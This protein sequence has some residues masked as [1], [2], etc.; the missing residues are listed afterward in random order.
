MNHKLTIDELPKHG[1]SAP[2]ST[3]TPKEEPVVFDLQSVIDNPPVLPVGFR[4]LI[5]SEIVEQTTESGIIMATDTEQKRRQVG[6]IWGTLIAVGETAFTGPDYTEADRKNAVPGKQV[7]FPRYA[8]TTFDRAGVVEGGAEALYR[9]MPDSDIM[10]IIAADETI[11][12]I[13]E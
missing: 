3:D 6:Q 5:R 8:G 11:N 9:I 4:V 12:V 7:L 2:F 13:E 1:N 10:A